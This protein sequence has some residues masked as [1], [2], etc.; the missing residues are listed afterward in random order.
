MRDGQALGSD[1]E[2]VN[3]RKRFVA[4]NYLQIK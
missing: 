1:D 2:V 3:R 4:K